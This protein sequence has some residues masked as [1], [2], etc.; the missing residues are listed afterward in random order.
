MSS[1]YLKKDQLNKRGRQKGIELFKA[2]SA[3]AWQLVKYTINR[4][5]N[6]INVGIER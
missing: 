5:G 4:N 6:Y 1:D 3:I 2:E